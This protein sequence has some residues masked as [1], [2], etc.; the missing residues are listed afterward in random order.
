M[1]RAVIPL[2]SVVLLGALA[3]KRG[4]P[5]PA[6]E[7]EP[8]A[9]VS[10]EEA[11]ALGRAFARAAAPCDPAALAPLIDEEAFARRAAR[12]ARSTVSP[13]S[14]LMAPWLCR[15][16]ADDTAV[17]LVAAR[18]VGGSVRAVLRLTTGE[19]LGYHELE[20]ARAAPGGAVKV[21]DLLSYASGEPLSAMMG[22]VAGSA[23]AAGD[24]AELA[25]TIMQVAR[26]EQAG[27]WAEAR[28]L[29]AS[30]PAH[31]RS[32]KSL[33]LK[34][35][36]LVEAEGDEGAYLAAIDG[37]ARDF[38][39]DPAADLLRFEG[40]RRRKDAPALL[41]TIE[42]LDRR[43][44]GDPYLA[45]KRAEAYLLDPTPAHLEEAERWARAATAGLPDREHGWWTLLVVQTKRRDHA[46][47]V[48]SL[49]ELQRR[50]GVEIDRDKMAGMT[51]F[52]DFMGSPEFA[53][54]AARQDAAAAAPAD[55]A[56]P[57]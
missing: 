6:P 32:A 42:R 31:L 36:Q 40:D 16:L 38:P 43:V 34:D 8:A 49:D 19:R 26:A 15:S 52:R 2:A 13:A 17:G 51:T 3:C 48:A 55:A 45:D 41:A 29:L 5:A 46:G 9:P 30:L 53:A 7:P 22:G 1:R 39:D 57:P 35:V 33:R 24:A 28:R 20:L 4:A 54:W 12:A 14:R 37:F 11:T 44:G 47:V 21:V 23:A 56:P 25:T 50:F 18:D 10:I 27:Q